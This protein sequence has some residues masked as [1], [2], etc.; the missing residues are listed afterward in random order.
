[1]KFKVGKERIIHRTSNVRCPKCQHGHLYPRNGSNDY[2]GFTVSSYSSNY[3]LCSYC[4]R[5]FEAVIE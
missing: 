3:W 2:P 5:E 1:M 4:R